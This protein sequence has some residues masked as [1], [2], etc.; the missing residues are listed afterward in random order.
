MPHAR[1]IVVAEAV[2]LALSVAA[3]LQAQQQDEVFFHIGVARYETTPDLTSED[4]RQI[5]GRATEALKIDNDGSQGGGHNDDVACNVTLQL[6]GEVRTYTNADGP[7]RVRGPQDF[8][9]LSRFPERIKL[10]VK[11]NWCGKY[12]AGDGPVG[13]GDID[14]DSIAIR[15]EVNGPEFK[16][17]AHEFGHNTGLYDNNKNSRAIMSQGYSFEKNEINAS[18]CRT[19]RSGPPTGLIDPSKKA[20]RRFP[21]QSDQAPS[22]INFVRQPWDHGIPFQVASRFEVSQTPILLNM[23]T[24]PEY[25]RFSGNIT[26]TLSAIG[27][28]EA[29]GKIIRHLEGD[30]Q[31]AAN[32]YAGRIGIPISLGWLVHQSGNQQALDY[33][34][35]H[36]EPD[37]WKGVAPSLSLPKMKEEERNMDLAWA[38]ITGLSLSGHPTAGVKI[39]SMLDEARSGKSSFIT[40]QDIEVLDDLFQTWMIVSEHGLI[41][42]YS[43]N[44]PDVRP[45]DD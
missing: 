10:V 29:V 34:V 7:G 1:L 37:A 4:A 39:R 6:A 25:A 5:F 36:A 32:G 16:R 9:R 14:G 27:S 3:P 17:W 13:C 38:A 8:N 30:I 43:G 15:R 22:I 11:I 18:A 12:V 40:N 45:R 26:A 20:M 35:A 21:P 28:S 24:N 31:D 33:L 41:G 19:Y 44:N 42:Y 23:L 2:S